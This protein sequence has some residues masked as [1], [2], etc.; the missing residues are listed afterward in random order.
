VRSGHRE[1]GALSADT[2]G[3]TEETGRGEKT[4]LLLDT[5]THTVVAECFLL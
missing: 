4:D 1:T 3:P 5:H 2:T